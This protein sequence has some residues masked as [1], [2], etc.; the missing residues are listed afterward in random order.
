MGGDAI[1]SDKDPW[2]VNDAETDPWE[3]PATVP[4][5]E[6]LG[7]R[8]LKEAGGIFTGSSVGENI[9]IVGP[10]ATKAAAGLVAAGESAFSDKKFGDVYNELMQ[11]DAEKAALAQK[12]H[13]VAE[14]VKSLAG[15][16]ALP[17]PGMGLAG[18]VAQAH[19]IV[20]G[21]AQLADAVVP[22]MGVTYG[23][24]LL[25]TMKG[26]DAENAAKEAGYWGAAAHVLP[27][28]IGATAK[29]VTRL[30]TGVKGEDISRY[31]SRKP[32]INAAE[33][34]DLVRAGRETV[35][36][37]TE[38]EIAKRQDLAKYIQDQIETIRSDARAGSS[39]AFEPLIESGTEIPL[40]GIKGNLTQQ[41]NE[42]K[43]G[44]AL[45]P[46]ASLNALQKERE[47]LDA[48]GL[49]SARPEE[50]KR[51]IMQLDRSL[52]P[53]FDKRK[54][55]VPLDE[56]ERAL[57]SHRKNI[58]EMLVKS[59]PEYDAAMAPVRDRM[60]VLEGVESYTGS[61]DKTYK[62]LERI[63]SPSMTG[64]RE[65]IEN[66]AP[67]QTENRNLAKEAVDINA[68]NK[69]LGGVTENSVEALA[70]RMT[71]AKPKLRDREAFAALSKRAKEMPESKVPMRDFD[72]YAKDLRTKK[73]FD[74]PYAQGSRNTNLGALS[75]MSLANM[76]GHG[77]DKIAPGL[78]AVIGAG[79][80]KLGPQTVKSVLDIISS[81]GGEKFARMYAKAAEQGPQA[82]ALTHE[83]LRQRDKTYND[84]LRRGV[85][86]Q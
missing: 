60:R 69:D 61:P 24:T 82:I 20:R 15:G 8:A 64:A 75:L 17:V 25:R 62:T 7:Q 47:F 33:M 50:L 85:A 48:T 63:E 31:L 22:Q 68:M 56:G 52:E 81:P 45:R 28:A 1:M 30:T 3:T 16:A 44:E 10:L 19:K 36:D 40:S 49:K 58:N 4:M 29:G 84:M 39:K 55:G 86:G 65:G 34:D 14:T 21:A 42:A 51:Y 70:N 46:S 77:L 59:V 76:A 53:A 54:M 12:E 38:T 23:D 9:P 78:G 41:I 13:P 2:E 73:V 43:L 79:L 11:H 57:M 32:Q 83:L 66:L 5:K 35:K 18:K 26:N 27:K 74:T 80:D 71:G 37:A 6:P 72:E 67:W